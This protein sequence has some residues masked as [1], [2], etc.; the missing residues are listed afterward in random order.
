M[1]MFSL[2]ALLQQLTHDAGSKTAR[3]ASHK[4]SALI[5]APARPAEQAAGPVRLPHRAPG[6]T[7]LGAAFI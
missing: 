1:G 7:S 4:N 5:A 3:P 6:G 2:Q